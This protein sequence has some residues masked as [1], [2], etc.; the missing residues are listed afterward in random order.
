MQ[1]FD[2]LRPNNRFGRK[3]NRTEAWP[4]NPNEFGA[5]PSARRRPANLRRRRRR[6]SAPQV[7]RTAPEASSRLWQ[8]APPFRATPSARRPLGP[9]SRCRASWHAARETP[10]AARA[11]AGGRVTGRTWVGCEKR[12]GPLRNKQTARLGTERGSAIYSLTTLVTRCGLVCAIMRPTGDSIF[13]LRG[14]W[15]TRRLWNESAPSERLVGNLHCGPPSS[16]AATFRT[17]STERQIDA[18]QADR[19]NRYALV[20]GIWP[21]DASHKQA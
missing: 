14:V 17:A 20:R 16:R 10:A 11:R 19:E 2:C 21:H 12:A 3:P 8:R 5:A 6:L 9:S 15:P 1:N 18:S 13:S 4:C 7:S